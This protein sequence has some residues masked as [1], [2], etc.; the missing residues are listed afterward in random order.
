M[1]RALDLA[2][3]AVPAII[4]I[5]LK[6]PS[7]LIHGDHVSGAEL[8]AGSTLDAAFSIYG[9]VHGF[10]FSRT[11]PSAPAVRKTRVFQW[12]LSFVG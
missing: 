7:L 12:A 3:S 11:G 9:K 5:T 4:G 10:S 6:G 8:G 1:F 2:D